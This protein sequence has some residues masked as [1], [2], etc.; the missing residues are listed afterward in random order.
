M[1]YGYAQETA[2][3]EFTKNQ[4]TKTE[5]AKQLG[6][7]RRTVGRWIDMVEEEK[8]QEKQQEKGTEV[9]ELPALAVGN[10][11]KFENVQSSRP[12]YVD[13]YNGRIAK[14]IDIDNSEY[15]RSVCLEF[16]VNGE[17]IIQFFNPLV[18]SNSYEWSLVPVEK[19]S[20]GI[21][22]K[23]VVG[24]KHKFVDVKDNCPFACGIYEG[25]EVEVV[26]I[27]P[28]EEIDQ[29][30]VILEIKQGDSTF[31]QEF[32]SHVHDKGIYKWSLFPVEDC[33]PDP[34]EEEGQLESLP[35]S[36]VMT[37]SYL[38]I[39]DGI[40]SDTITSDHPEF[41]EFYQ[42][43]LD[44]GM[45]QQVL[46]RV[47]SQMNVKNIIQSYKHNDIEVDIS[48]EQVKYKGEVVHGVVVDRI[49]QSAKQNNGSVER[50]V[51]FLEN[52]MDNPSY[53]AVNELYSFLEA[54]DIEI[55]E[56]G[57]VLCFKKVTEDYMD[58]RTRTF[59]NSVGSTPRVERWQVD[60]DMRRTCSEGLHVC[61][62]SYLKFYG[63]SV[64]NRVVKVRVHPA[65][66][67]SIPIDYNFA[68]ARVCKYEVLADV[69]DKI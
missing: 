33:Q 5:I 3:I 59:D 47:R 1:T 20:K 19:N 50:L 46:Q 24:Q 64:S 32:S 67:V 15:D 57:Y 8:Q 13:L 61:S 66:F 65:D 11:Y 18:Y 53:R 43:I 29:W 7:S 51:K 31:T 63:S 16:D 25:C 27:D 35:L 10:Y 58:I 23:L 30:T 42:S 26:S 55:D 62:K 9:R 36:V 56:D 21:V 12:F 22:D 34:E 45:S 39:S 48:T 44:F 2:H 6:V 52:L 40:D 49:V 54:A 14:V 37:D 28:C 68:K 17:K 4:K 41:A 69:T 60:E 38:C